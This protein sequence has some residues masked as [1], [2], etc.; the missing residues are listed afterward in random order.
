MRA[1]LFRAWI[2]ALCAALLSVVWLA[3]CSGETAETEAAATPADATAAPVVVIDATALPV[4]TP[5]FGAEDSEATP[6]PSD[7]PK[8][9]P[10]LSI[11]TGRELPVDRL[12]QPVLAVIGNAPQVRP[13]TGLGDADIIYEFSL[14]RTDHA[15][16][17]V[18]LFSD[19]DPVRIGPIQEARLYFFELQRE[20]EAMFVYDGYPAD[21]NYAR[22]DL[23][24]IDLPAAYAESTAQYFV[25]DKTVSADPEN[26]LFCNLTQMRGTLYGATSI[27]A[28][29]ARFSFEA[30]VQHK[31]AK[32]FIKVGVPFTSSD[33][34]KIEFVYNA[35]D[36]RIYRYER[37]S[38]GTLV[39]SKTLTTS[40][41]GT[42]VA[43]KPLSVQNLIIQHVKYDDV[44]NTPYRSASLTGSGECDFFVNG[45][46]SAGRW[47]RASLG[48]PTVYVL[49]D[50]SPLV[51]EP[52]TTWI[53]F[54]PLSRKIKIQYQK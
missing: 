14:D 33:Y 3:A 21:A 54:Q 7:T 41:D 5:V 16:R 37:N 48:D 29:R 40:A 11:T 8:P 34:A 1:R 6:A 32:P 24:T 13:Q 15:T 10:N 47:S 27:S 23:N 22:Y 44:P 52:G 2:P 12:F 53:A 38:K 39:A 51:L 25:Q 31:S 4:E 17:L 49:R 42:A 9:T 19:N 50:G 26:M 28:S 45:R 35:V 36:N 18:A 46:H 30:G 20:W 43:S